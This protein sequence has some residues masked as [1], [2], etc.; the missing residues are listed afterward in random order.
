M[1]HAEV[2][3]QLEL[4]AVEPGG[5]E[6]L[7]A[8]DTADASAVAGHLVG[9]EACGEELRR[10][11]ASVGLIRGVV[12][13]IPAPELR[14]R[15]L[16]Y[17]AEVGRDRGR[18]EVAAEPGAETAVEAAPRRRRGTPQ[19]A[20][21]I[22]AIAAAVAIAVAG[23]LL[24]TGAPRNGDLDRRADAVAALERV[25]AASLRVAA[26]PDAARVALEPTG[27]PGAA[28]GSGTLLFSPGSRELVVVASGLARPPEGREFRCWFEVGGERR[29][30]GRMYFADELSFWVGAVDAVGDL[31][32]GSRF[33]ITLVPAG[34]D[35]L[36]GAPALVGEL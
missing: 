13:S 30:V 36:D 20:R 29:P 8:G 24:V 27:Q 35:A 9:C 6:R 19:L 23:T 16:R 32:P 4:A 22:A 2:H 33:G 11:H 34:G 12:R 14:E 18:T 5:I 15:T 3:E 1:N 26:E 31:E 17:I 7:M 28:A 21:W 25:T 10:L